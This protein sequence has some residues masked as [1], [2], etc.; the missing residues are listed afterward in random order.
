VVSHTKGDAVVGPGLL[1]R[2]CGTC[3]AFSDRFKDAVQTT[4]EMTM[5]NGE[6]TY[7][8]FSARYFT[9]SRYRLGVEAAESASHHTSCFAFP[10]RQSPSETRRTLP[11][12]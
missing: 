4:T 9:V 7:R 12:P 11:S 10:S 5:A 3:N 6:Q 8:S 2:T 1:R